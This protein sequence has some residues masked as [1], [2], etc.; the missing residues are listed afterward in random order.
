MARAAWV[1][2]LIIGL[3]VEQ[4]C[5]QASFDPAQVFKHDGDPLHGVRVP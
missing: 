3:I 2:L 1:L 5:S 4:G